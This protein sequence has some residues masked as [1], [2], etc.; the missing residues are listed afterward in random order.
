MASSRSPAG[1]VHG[2]R[3]RVAE[4]SCTRRHCSWR[5]CGRRASR[6]CPRSRATMREPECGAALVVWVIL[7]YV[8]AGVIA[9]WRRPESRLARS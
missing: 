8:L 1:A 6:L 5:L 3:S 2:S 9:W 7:T 4:A